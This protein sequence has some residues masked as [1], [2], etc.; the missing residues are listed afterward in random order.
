MNGSY[1]CNAW[2]VMHFWIEKHKFNKFSNFQV[3]TWLLFWCTCH[4]NFSSAHPRSCQSKCGHS[5]IR[6]DN[7]YQSDNAI[8]DTWLKVKKFR[9]LPESSGECSQNSFFFNI[10]IV[11]WK[12]KRL[13]SIFAKIELLLD[14]H[15]NKH[16]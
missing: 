14:S 13:N 16:Y 1:Q 12:Q 4:L 2:E 9:F 8:S 11:A 7:I 6:Y 3:H 10:Y 15:S 5:A